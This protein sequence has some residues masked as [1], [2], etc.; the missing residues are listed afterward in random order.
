MKKFIPLLLLVVLPHLSSGQVL[1][2]HANLD[3]TQAAT[4]STGTGFANAWLDVPTNVLTFDVTWTG[5][6]SAT[7]N[8]HIHRGAPGVNGPVTVPFPGLP[9]GQTFGTYAN[10][11][12][13]TAPLVADLLGGLDYVNIH[14]VNFPAGEIRGQLL[15]AP[16][17]VPEPSTYA[18]S[19]AAFLLLLAFRR[20]RGVRSHTK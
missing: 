17:P 2:F 12:T 20:W 9:L 13:L 3:G 5:L 11:F 10:T 1:F 19:G 16:N 8:G 6:G 4:P 14:S 18:A 15:A 7:T